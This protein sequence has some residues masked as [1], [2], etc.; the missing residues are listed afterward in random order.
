MKNYLSDIF[1][2]YNGKCS[3]LN[4]WL[5]NNTA[6]QLWGMGVMPAYS[7]EPYSCELQGN[8][9]G[10]MLSGKFLSPSVNKQKYFLDV[11]GDIIG[12][13]RYAKYLDKKKEWIVYRKF[14]LKRENEIIGLIF[15]S[16]LEKHDDAS[17]S[18]VVLVKL[19]SGKVVSSFFY[20]YDDK[21]SEK[22]YLYKDNKII[23]IEQRMWLDTY[24]EHYFTI[25]TSPMLII[26]EKIDN[27]IIRIYPN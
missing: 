16:S 3:E 21:F 22:K 13:V 25:E 27:G 4:I 23:N 26:N 17:L 11:N 12:E 1:K 19:E 7:L 24:I 2:K 6:D 9:P 20:S 18:N 10:R 5:E 8:Q 14:Y 15:G